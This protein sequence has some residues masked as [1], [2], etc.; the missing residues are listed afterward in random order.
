MKSFDPLSLSTWIYILNFSTSAFK[1]YV[2]S[3][4]YLFFEQALGLNPDIS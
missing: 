1:V 4:L 3:I 2:L